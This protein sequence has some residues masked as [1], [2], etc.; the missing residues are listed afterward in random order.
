MQSDAEKPL[1]MKVVLWVVGKT[2][3]SYLDTGIALY[4][5]RLERYLPF[6]MEVIPD[7]RR[8]G[9]LPAEQLREQEGQAI[10]GRLKKEDFLILLDE[11][12]KTFGSE[13]FA[14]FIEQQLGQ[15][16]NRLIFLVG[17]AYGFSPALYERADRLL[18]LSAMTFSHQ[19]VRLFFL[20]QLYRA[21]TILRNEPYHNR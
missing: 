6:E 2:S 18:S 11:K 7:I 16:G 10:L 1:N 4:R 14:R 3:E 19:M 12:G 17:G 21:M 8:G 9:K 13:D 20:E 15:P 5:K